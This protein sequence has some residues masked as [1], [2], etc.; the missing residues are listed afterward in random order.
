M[1]ETSRGRANSPR[2]LLVRRFLADRS[3]ELEDRTVGTPGNDADPL[4][5]RTAFQCRGGADAA[6]QQRRRAE[7][8]RS[9]AQDELAAFPKTSQVLHRVLHLSMGSEEP[10]FTNIESIL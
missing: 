3:F 5:R 7:R 4:P 6:R 8:H 1:K 9:R 10:W 2:L